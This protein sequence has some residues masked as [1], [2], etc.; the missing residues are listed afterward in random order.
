MKNK[1][2]IDKEHLKSLRKLRW[3]LIITVAVV[4]IIAI[5]VALLLEYLL[6]STNVITEKMIKESLIL[7][8]VIFGGT[9]II[10]GTLLFLVAGKIV[11]KP[12]N[13]LLDGMNSLANGK[14]ETRIDFKEFPQISNSFNSLAKEL[15]NVQI[16][17]QDFINNFSHEF[18]TPIVSIKGLVGL[19]KNKKLTKEKEREYL[20]VIDEEINRLSLITTNV[21][22]LSKLDNQE[23]LTEYASFNLSEQIRRIVLLFERQ[24]SSKN[25]TFKMDFDE[26]V[27]NGNEDMLKQ[28]WVNLID[29]AIK[30]ADN[31]TEIEINVEKLNSQILVSVGDVGVSILDED[32]DKIF[33]KF[34]QV[35][36]TYSKTGNGIGL[37]IVKKII[38]LHKG[39]VSVESLNNKTIFTVKLPC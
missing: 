36:N 10:T 14:Y 20:E 18:K 15:E 35:D 34:Y 17:R 1:I 9:S 39:A 3:T 28:V 22:N 16:L 5:G 19:M 4:L 6:I 11:L 23:I 7:V 8:G 37:S 13:K 12:I 30:F 29:N 25:L 38:K 21:L 2:K 26:V 27:V 32:K 31:S 24:W 33:N